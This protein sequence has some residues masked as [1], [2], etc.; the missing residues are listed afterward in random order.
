ME[1]R[2]ELRVELR[3]ALGA[4]LSAM[5][6]SM[7]DQEWTR[8]KSCRCRRSVQLTKLRTGTERRVARTR[9]TAHFC[10][11][12]RLEWHHPHTP[13]VIL[14]LCGGRPVVF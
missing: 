14:P 1:L 12:V 4:A 2:V 8:L 13:P 5:T 9:G 10:F 6:Q 11:Q 7:H 3:L